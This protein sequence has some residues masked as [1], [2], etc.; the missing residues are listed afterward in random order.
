MAKKAEHR[1]TKKGW[2]GKIDPVEAGLNKEIKTFRAELGK[3][4]DREEEKSALYAR[5]VAPESKT[6]F[7]K[8]PSVIA[9][10]KYYNDNLKT[11]AHLKDLL[12][13][14]ERNKELRFEFEKLKLHL[15]LTHTK[16]DETAFAMLRGFAD[17]TG[18]MA[19]IVDF[20]GGDRINTTEDRSV[21]HM[22]LR[23][24]HDEHL[25]IDGEDV[26]HDVHIQLDRIREFSN[27][28]RLGEIVGHTEKQFKNIVVVGM[29][30][31]VLGPEFVYEA[32]R[33]D[34]A[35]R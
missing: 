33:F 12:N 31:S 2:I 13:D 4:K 34:E 35:C 15:D 5:A 32:L 16:I 14:V 26:V 3:H 17:Q 7:D 23:M 8:L 28:V 11:S 25:I 30:G 22:A 18:L 6:T 29:G 9:L 1:R 21:C 24:E 27:A 20:F 10:K 19:K